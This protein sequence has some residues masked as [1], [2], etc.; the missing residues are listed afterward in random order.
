MSNGKMTIIIKD[1][2][3]TND[4]NAIELLNKFIKDDINK[5]DYKSLKY[6]KM[7]L[8]KHKENLKV[9]LRDKD[10]VK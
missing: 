3:R 2:S 4:L 9:K 1:D 6:H 7:A 10:V 5:K 8:K